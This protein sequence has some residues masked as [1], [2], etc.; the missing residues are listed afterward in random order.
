MGFFYDT[1]D[2]H[3][4]NLSPTFALPLILIRSK[5]NQQNYDLTSTAS[6]VMPPLSVAMFLTKLLQYFAVFCLAIV[7]DI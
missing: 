4:R 2:Y 6:V 5:I 3:T 7:S 1:S